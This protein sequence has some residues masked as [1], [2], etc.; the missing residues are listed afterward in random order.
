MGEKKETSE[1]LKLFLK[2]E[3]S[4]RSYLLALTRSSER[5]DEVFQEVSLT[6]WERFGG[7]DPRYPFVNWA[8]GVARNHVARWRR[9][10]AGGPVA[11]SPE[12]E[13]KLA[14]TYAEL[15]D[16][17]DGRRQ[18]LRYCLEKLGEHARQL[19]DLRYE[20]A[21]TLRQIA[22][23]RSMTLN[24][25][26]KALGKIR[27]ALAQCTEHVMRSGGSAPEGEGA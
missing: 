4:L 15:E 25:A 27:R 9:S 2:A 7:Y 16:E 19:I 1:F 8:M 5:A 14:T 26:N 23:A 20:K 17:L 18:A 10:R 13:A 12:V 3:P 11:L 24:A 6:L 21:Y 22:D